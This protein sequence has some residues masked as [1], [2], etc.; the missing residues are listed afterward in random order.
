M[1][2]ADPEPYT[3]NHFFEKLKITKTPISSQNRRENV[4]W[5]GGSWGS[6]FDTAFFKGWRGFPRALT[7][8]FVA[9]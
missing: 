9:M 5:R 2:F 1:I 3:K 8:T 4:A 6:D 7:L